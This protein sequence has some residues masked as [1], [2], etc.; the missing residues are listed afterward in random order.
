MLTKTLVYAQNAA[1]EGLFTPPDGQVL[2]IVGQD[3]DALGGLPDHNSGYLDHIGRVTGGVTSYTGMPDLGGLETLANWG[4]GDVCAQC[5]LESPSYENMVI[6]LGFWMAAG[7]EEQVAAGNYDT[8]IETLAQWIKQAARPVY[9]RIGYE[10]DGQWNDYEPTAY[11]NAYRRIV[12][13]LRAAEV[14]NVAFVWQS[15]THN[16]P[17]YGGY[18]W[19]DWY[20]GDEYVDWFGLSYFEPREDILTAFLELA[21]THHKPVMIA[22]ATPRGFDLGNTN[23]P[24]GVWNI[25]FAPF[26]EFIHTNQDVIRAVAYINVD[27]DSQAMWHDQGWGDSRVEA[28]E[29]VRELWLTEVQIDFWLKASPDLF[30]QLGYN[31]TPP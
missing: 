9:L 16:T 14:N 29:T 2:L 23:N 4:S 13:H 31:V 26:F 11:V 30:E 1:I 25:W 15:A 20:P 24:E 21:R 27:W 19:L 28:N 18:E 5:M 22:E 3:L 10:F 6:A 12:D 17:R 8:Q 7:Y